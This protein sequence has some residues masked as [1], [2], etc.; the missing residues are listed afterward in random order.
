MKMIVYDKICY[1]NTGKQIHC[2]DYDFTITI[3]INQRPILYYFKLQSCR[4][5]WVNKR[6][7]FFYLNPICLESASATLLKNSRNCSYSS[8]V[9]QSF[10]YLI[11]RMAFNIPGV[12]LL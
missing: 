9:T 11:S 3:I 4:G 7:V 10:L 2:I 6:I 12:L 5:F 8:G 1:D